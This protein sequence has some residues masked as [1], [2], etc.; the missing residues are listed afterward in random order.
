MIFVYTHRSVPCLV[1]ITEA[2][3]GSR[4]EWV[5]RYTVIHCIDRESKWLVSIESLPSEIGTSHGTQ[6][7]IFQELEGMEDTKKTWPMELTKRGSHGLTETEMAS[8]GPSWI[9]TRSS[10]YIVWLLTWCSGRIPNS[11]GMHSSDSFAC[12]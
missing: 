7:E 3:S 8:T 6:K 5:Q 11:G 4:W 9:Y 10:V 1:I 12:S 2:S